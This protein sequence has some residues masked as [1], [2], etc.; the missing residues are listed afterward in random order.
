MI[1][2]ISRKNCTGNS[3]IAKKI[4][5]LARY[6]PVTGSAAT[7]TATSTTFLIPP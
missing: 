3:F 7:V 1:R 2:K 6:V 4:T 5:P